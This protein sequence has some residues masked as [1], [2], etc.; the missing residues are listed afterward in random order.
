[1]DLRFWMGGVLV[2]MSLALSLLFAR[3]CVRAFKARAWPQVSAT[4]TES[5]LNRDYDGGKYYRFKV[6]YRYEVNGREFVGEKL[7]VHGN[8]AWLWAWPVERQVRQYP[9]GA[10]VSVYYSPKNPADAVLQPGLGAGF[11]LMWALALFVLVGSA[12]NQFLTSVTE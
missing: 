1:M 8:S 7:R 12:L 2:L 9:V 4:V 6:A 11:L 10:V 3:Q 5:S